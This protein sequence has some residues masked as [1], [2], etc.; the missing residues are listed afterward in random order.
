[1]DTAARA[2][3]AARETVADIEPPALRAVLLDR[4]ETTSMAP[5]VLVLVSATGRDSSVAIEPLLDRAVGVQLIY[6]GLRLTRSL[7]HE[8][9]WTDVDDT[10]IDADLDI[11]A[12]DVLVSRGFSL[13]ATTEA[14]AAAVETVQAFGRDQTT[15]RETA[16]DDAATLDRNLEADIFALAVRAGVTAV[17]GDPSEA[18]LGDAAAAAREYDNELPPATTVLTDSFRQRLT[19][20]ST[21][22]GGPVASSVGDP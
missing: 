8:E 6:E 5:G 4:L 20:P 12:A 17:G 9:P 19:D 10:E 2:R 7:A 22:D 14:S 13:L 11:L 21:G 15:R 3:T 18:L 16:T 1:M